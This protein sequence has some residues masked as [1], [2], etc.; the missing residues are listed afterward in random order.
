MKTLGRVIRDRRKE[1][2][3]SQDDLADDLGVTRG[4]VAK[5]ETDAQIPS[6]KILNALAENLEIPK[7]RLFQYSEKTRPL[8]S[9]INQSKEYD[10][11][12]AKLSNEMKNRLLDMVE[13]IE[14]W[15]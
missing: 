10:K 1:F 4:Y 7:E 5:I 14:K 11:R 3:W 6:V 2:G 9:T 15:D 8:V 13:L 12:W